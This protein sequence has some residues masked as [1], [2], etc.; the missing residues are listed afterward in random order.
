MFLNK[1]GWHK[2]MSVCLCIPVLCITNKHSLLPLET[3]GKRQPKGSILVW[4]W[5][6]VRPRRGSSLLRLP[7]E[8][9]RHPSWSLAS[10]LAISLFLLA[11]AWGPQTARHHPDPPLLSPQLRPKLQGPRPQPHHKL[12]FPPL[13][14]LLRDRCKRYLGRNRGQGRASF[15]KG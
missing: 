14:T 3:G 6:Y 10:P 12:V 4:G 11:G 13:W 8:V 1:K 7:S 15:F 9:P 2:F 5:E